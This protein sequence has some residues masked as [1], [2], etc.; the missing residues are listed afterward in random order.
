M[1]V[2][3]TENN[4]IYEKRYFEDQE[5]QNGFQYFIGFSSVFFTISLFSLL[6]LYSTFKI[7]Y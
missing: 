2:I 6:F 3:P 1:I 5:L 4:W 7:L